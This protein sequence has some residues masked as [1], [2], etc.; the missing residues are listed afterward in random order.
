MRPCDTDIYGKTASWCDYSTHGD[1]AEVGR[2][3]TYPKISPRYPKISQDTPYRYCHLPYRYCHLKVMFNIDMVKFHIDTV[4]C[5][6]SSISII[7]S[8][9]CALDG[10]V[11]APRR[12]RHGRPV[13]VYPIKPTLRAPETKCLKLRYGELLSSFAFKFNL[14]C[15]GMGM[16]R[17]HFHCW[18]RWVGRSRLTLSNPR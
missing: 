16:V 17:C 12:V 8:C 3:T 4:I 1:V 6:S 18:P 2:V 5:R 15:Y 7:I 11:R 10:G 9:H 13:Q 14:R